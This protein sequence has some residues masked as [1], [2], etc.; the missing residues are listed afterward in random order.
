M[1]GGWIL[2]QP[3]LKTLN[4]GSVSTHLLKAIQVLHRACDRVTNLQMPPSIWW[5]CQNDKLPTS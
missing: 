3:S 4:K 2:N 1:M 5:H